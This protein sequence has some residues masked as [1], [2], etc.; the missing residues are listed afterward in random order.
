MTSFHE[1]FVFQQGGMSILDM[2][3]DSKDELDALGICTSRYN[4]YKGTN[5]NG[6]KLVELC[7]N[8]DLHIV[9]GRFG[10][11]FKVGNLTCGDKSC[12]D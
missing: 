1:D 11:D 4:K 12:I 8:C 3:F 6:Y 9:N 2:N 5:N 7:K 10:S